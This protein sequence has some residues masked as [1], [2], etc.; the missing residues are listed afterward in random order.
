MD[1]EEEDDEEEGKK[2]KF[3]NKFN[4]LADEKSED[5]ENAEN[6][7]ET[8]SESEQEEQDDDGEE[9]EDEE[10]HKEKEEEV[11]EKQT[12]IPNQNPSP[13]TASVENKEI[14]IADKLNDLKMTDEERTESRILNRHELIYFLKSVHKSPDKAKPGVIL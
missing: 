9:E 1:E 5:D 13:Q 8:E 10:E 14:I 2:N 4:L 6:E 7:T 3:A 12:T 11:K